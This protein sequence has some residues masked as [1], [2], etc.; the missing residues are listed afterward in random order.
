MIE[1]EVSPEQILSLPM[2]EAMNMLAMI[3]WVERVKDQP[4]LTV[5]DVMTIPLREVL[6]II[7]AAEAD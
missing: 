2:V 6:D 3:V 5:A 7:A 4:A 1:A